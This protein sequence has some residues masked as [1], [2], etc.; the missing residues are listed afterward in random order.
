[1]RCKFCGAE[2]AEDTTVCTE[3]GKDNGKDSL[4]M[5]QKKVKNMRIALM[6]LF[7]A[8]VLIALTT[9]VVLSI[10][11]GMDHSD[12]QPSSTGATA[13]P[14]I[15]TDGNPDD[16]TCKGS[17]T[18]TDD[19]VKANRDTVVATMGD[20]KLT[21][22]QFSVYYWNALYDFLSDYGSYASYFGLDISKPLDSQ[23]CSVFE[24]PMSWQQSFIKQAV[25]TWS[26][27]QALALE[28]KKA[29]FTLPDV[30]AD[31]LKDLPKTLE[32]AAQKGKFDS[33][34]ALLES[35]YGP[36]CTYDD[37]YSYMEIYYL[38]SAYYEDLKENLELTDE[39]LQTYFD[40]NKESL[41]T[42][43]GIETVNCPLISVRHILIQPEGGTTT[44]G[45]TTYTDEAWKAC[46]TKAQQ[47]YDAWKSGAK[48]EETFIESAKLNSK[49]GNAQQGG[50]YEDVYSGMMVKEFND[51]CFD[52][53]RQYGDH[54]LVKTQFG[55][56]IMFFVDSYEGAHP[57]IT[58]GA[59]QE[60]LSGFLKDVTQNSGAD[61]S[62]ESILVNA[63]DVSSN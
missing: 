7:A 25:E 40:K 16:H 29:G 8:V 27:Y 31:A 39:Q 3:C 13:E 36:G 60:V 46:E 62:Y 47:I 18:A 10:M 17:Y 14:T 19:Q 56:H 2:M 23:L 33:V 15:P 12:T 26:T 34:A 32:D 55:Y 53:S 45:V 41:K 21:N 44:N 52:E 54:G 11:N 24:E 1:M 38:G 48:T 30:Y 5:L 28:A 49:D 57:A 6:V 9:V 61:V 4:D 42:Q 50:I 58:S 59:S 20:V 35:D 22:S 43:Y 37:Y 51:W 63:M